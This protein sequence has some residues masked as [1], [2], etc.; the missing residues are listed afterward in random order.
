MPGARGRTSAVRQPALLQ[1][2]A[3]KFR[4]DGTFYSWPC[5]VRLSSKES[6][7]CGVR[8]DAHPVEDEGRFPARKR[9]S[10]RSARMA[11]EGRLAPIATGALRP[12]PVVGQMWLS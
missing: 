10:V 4:A 7:A 11:I 8:S 3:A 6:T 12:R 5:R 2:M 9:P 1:Q